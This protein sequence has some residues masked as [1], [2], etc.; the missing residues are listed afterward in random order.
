MLLS[1]YIL[2]DMS[3]YL[4][5]NSYLISFFKP[6]NPKSEKEINKIILNPSHRGNHSGI[7]PSGL[8]HR[9]NK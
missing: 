7:L 2:I 4:I 1:Q 9:T 3:I 5:I 6:E 8:L